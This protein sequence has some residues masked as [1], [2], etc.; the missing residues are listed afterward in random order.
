MQSP[1]YRLQRLR[2][3][4]FSVQ[5]PALRVFSILRHTCCCSLDLRR[6]IEGSDLPVVAV[7]EFR[8][9]KRDRH[10]VPARLFEFGMHSAV[11]AVKISQG[12]SDGVAFEVPDLFHLSKS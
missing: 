1:S 12:G 7:R 6:G 4:L 9:A 10:S 2:Q 5:E 3:R 11:N 8:P